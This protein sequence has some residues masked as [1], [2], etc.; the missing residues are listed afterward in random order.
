M[1]IMTMR[2]SGR[3]DVAQPHSKTPSVLFDELFLYVCRHLSRSAR[4]IYIYTNVYIYTWKEWTRLMEARF[5]HIDIHIH[6]HLH[7]HTY[8]YTYTDIHTHLHAYTYTYTYT[9]T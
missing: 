6:V 5:I 3:S 9:Y 4:D 7:I 8:T 2:K 1:E